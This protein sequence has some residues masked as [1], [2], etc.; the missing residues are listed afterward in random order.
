VSTR[1][2]KKAVPGYLSRIL[3]VLLMMPFFASCSGDHVDHDYF[4]KAEKSFASGEL[5][6][7][8]QFYELFL[9]NETKSSK[10]M[11][12]WERLLLIHLDMGRD[13][14]QGMYILKSMSLEKDVD[15]D[16]LWSVYM[17]I[18][19]LYFHQ[20]LYERS[21]EVLERALE[22]AGEKEQLIRTCESLAESYFR[23]SDYPMALE[24]L[25][26]CLEKVSDPSLDHT[27]AL[28]YLLGKI[29]Y[30]LNDQDMAIYYLRETLYSAAE[31]NYRS[32]AGI[33]L[34]DAYLNENDHKKAKE[35]MV[36]LEKF[37]PN[38]LVIRMRQENLR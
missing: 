16:N 19:R 4:Y 6:E 20:G 18:G 35:I 2:I 37:Y 13:V 11:Q 22:I 27:G 31:K 28:H 23:K 3:A 10:R 26:V 15:Q 12:A 29:Y 17:R 34:Y 7:A 33:L 32:K 1:F 14:E 8:A 9:E 30:Q 38:P 5:R 21:T 36:E 25:E 24:V